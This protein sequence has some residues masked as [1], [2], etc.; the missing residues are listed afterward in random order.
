MKKLLLM[1]YILSNG[2]QIIYSN[3]ENQILQE[4]HNFEK[5]NPQI[6]FLIDHGIDCEYIQTIKEK[7][8]DLF[9]NLLNHH[10]DENGHTFLENAIYSNDAEKVQKLINLGVDVKGNKNHS[11]LHCAAI[12][13]ADQVISLL[14]HAGADI[15]KQ[16]QYGS[17]PLHWAAT[18][19][20]NAEKAFWLLV[21]FNADLTIQDCDGHTAIEMMQLKTNRLKLDQA[22][23]KD[24]GED[25]EKKDDST[26]SKA[27]ADFLARQQAKRINLE[28]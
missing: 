19:G 20:E 5:L 26:K 27:M 22:A 25:E 1:L 24:D 28:N 10:H 18:E 13:N 2:T 8:P 9:L 14:I 23:T 15:N 12:N 7:N 11:P 4:L 21:K 16:T 17:T 6:I 3:P